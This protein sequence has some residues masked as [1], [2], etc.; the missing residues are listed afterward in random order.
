MTAWRGIMVL[1][2]VAAALATGWHYHARLLTW[3][4]P[5]PSAAHPS[6]TPDV[7]YTWVDDKGVTHFN[8]QAGKGARVEFDGSRITPIPALEPSLFD[9]PPMRDVGSDENG[10][11]PPFDGNNKG[12]DKGSKMLHEMRREMQENALRMKKAREV[13]AGL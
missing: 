1:V 8:Q 5:P 12:A 4:Q 11:N 10:N 7:L 6:P 9:A 2:A 3:M 13:E